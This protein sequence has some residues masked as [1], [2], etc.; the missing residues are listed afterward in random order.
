MGVFGKLMHATTTGITAA[1]NDWRQGPVPSTWDALRARYAE[2]YMI[3][4]GELFL[5]T[6]R[7]NPYKDDPR[8]YRNI[9]LLWN[10]TSRVVSF[11]ATL[12]YQGQLSDEPGEGAIP[13]QPDPMLTRQDADADADVPDGPDTSQVGNLMRAIGVL[14]Q[15]W[16]WQQK[17][18]LRPRLAA[19]LGDVLT[20][21]IDDTERRFPYPRIVW[22][23]YVKEIELDYVDNVLSYTLEHQITETHDH[24]QSETYL[25]RKEVDAEAFRYFKNDQPFDYFGDG[26]VVPNAYGFVP[27][28]WDRHSSDGISVRGDAATDPSR[29]A[30]FNL[31]SLL[32]H[33]RDFQHKAFFAPVVVAGKISRE[34]EKSINLSAPSREPSAMAMSLS[35]LEGSPDA[36]IHQANFDIGQTLAQLEFMRDG[37]LATHPEATFFDKLADAANVTG[38]GADRIILPVKGLVE[39]ARASCD[40]GTVRLFQMAISI[41]GMRVNAG[42]WNYV[43]GPDTGTVRQL[44]QLDRRREAF[45]PYTLESFDRGEM[46]FTIAARSIVIPSKAE[47]IEMAMQTESL[48]TLWGLRQAGVDGD[49]AEQMLQD[50]QGRY[51]VAVNAGAFGEDY[52]EEG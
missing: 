27:A 35:F 3:A 50:K 6:W 17:M 38:P 4:R 51:A 49:E 24:G 32:S 16:N 25:Y 36:T 28:V 42:D 22:P 21:L 20:E 9:S 14:Q 15:K 11:Y 12:V 52:G 48:N 37:I 1:V 7:N 45:R 19:E 8:V 10:H 5:D 13:I 29:Q 18:V 39:H 46:D 43:S 47:V 31:N 41:C 40:S 26:S 2:R 30:L 34:G 44:R 23:G 33:S